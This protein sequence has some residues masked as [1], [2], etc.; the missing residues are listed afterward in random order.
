MHT[1]SCF[2][3]PIAMKWLQKLYLY[4]SIYKIIRMNLPHMKKWWVTGWKE[5]ER[6]KNT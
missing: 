1:A 2:N 6:R 4:A 5:N 3:I